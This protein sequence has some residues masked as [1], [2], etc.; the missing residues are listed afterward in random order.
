MN[1]LEKTLDKSH[2]MCYNKYVIKGAS[3]P[4]KGNVKNEKCEVF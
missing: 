4:K 1:F 2:S 3:A